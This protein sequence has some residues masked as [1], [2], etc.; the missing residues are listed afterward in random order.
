MNKNNLTLL[1]KSLW[2]FYLNYGF[3]GLKSLVLLWMVAFFFVTIGDGV[4]FPNFQRWV[5]ALFE[6]PIPEGVN[7]IQYA[8]PRII[9]LT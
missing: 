7:L 9:F 2:R 1:P 6:K 4:I 5:V 8:L 3:N